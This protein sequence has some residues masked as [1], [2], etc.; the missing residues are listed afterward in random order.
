M[1]TKFFFCSGGL[2]ATEAA[3]KFI[4]HYFYSKGQEKRNRIITIEGGFHGRSIAAISAGGNKKSR[5]GFA[6]LLS[7]FDKVPRN[8]V[9]TLE[10]KISNETAAVF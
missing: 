6:P 1:Q 10:E 3:I 4:R 9:R 2:E 7:G 5:E 8:D